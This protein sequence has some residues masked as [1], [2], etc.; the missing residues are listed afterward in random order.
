[1]HMFLH[2]Y[3]FPHQHIM[4]HHFSFYPILTYLSQH[5]SNSKNNNKS[6]LTWS[7]CLENLHFLNAQT[8]KRTVSS[9]DNLLNNKLI[10]SLVL[11]NNMQYGLATAYT[12]WYISIELLTIN[13]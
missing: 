2:V 10:L 12:L 11:L 8:E 7:F 6:L 3:Y 5:C 1:M 13:I 4:E 9:I